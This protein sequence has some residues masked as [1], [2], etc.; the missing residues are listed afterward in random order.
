MVRVEIAV[1][2]ISESLTAHV[3]EDKADRVFIIERLSSIEHQLAK[4]HGGMIAV[5]V[6]I[7]AIWAALGLGMFVLAWRF[8][9]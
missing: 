7:S 3:G 4:W 8:P 6:V 1:G 5:G 2:H 9:S